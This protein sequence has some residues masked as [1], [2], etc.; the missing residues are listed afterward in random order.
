VEFAGRRDDQVKLRGFRVELGEV[1]AA[2]R[3]HPAVNAAAV[4]IRDTGFGDS[5][6]VGYVAVRDASEALTAELRTLLASRL[7]DYAVPAM[8]VALDHLPLTPNGKIDRKALPLPGS[9]EQTASARARRLLTPLE[10]QLLVIWEQV[11]GRDDLSVTDNFFDFGGNSLTAVRLFSQL[12]KVFGKDLPLATL[13]QAPTVERL[14][15]L[16]HSEG[17]STRWKTLVA[18]QPGGG[19]TPLF[20]VPGVGGNVLEFAR[21]A[22]LLGAEQPFYGAQSRGL[23]GKEPPLRVVQEMAREYLKEIRE[24]QPHGP[25]QLGG[26]CMG[27]IVAFEMAQQLEAAGERVALLALVDTPLT[28]SLNRK[29]YRLLSFLHPIFFVG[30]GISRHLSNLR[31]KSR[32]EWWAAVRVVLGI[33]GQMI[34]Q[35]DVYRGDR[36]VLY[37]DVVTAANY[38]AMANYVPREYRGRLHLFVASER[39]VNPAHYSRLDWAKFAAGGFSVF[40]INA[41][42]SGELLR[43]PY[44]SELAEQLRDA[45]SAGA[46]AGEIAGTVSDG[47][48]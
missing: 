5:Y 45:L 43:A 25:Y 12:R 39:P 47:D 26:A 31:G 37:Q 38:E 8:F 42:D 1:E 44:V 11:L 33:V 40:R 9:V 16:M 17:R 41:K 46:T 22:N 28:R 2:L 24:L 4:T 6:L 32:A 3:Q 19:S 48:S 23:D 7:P 21:L 35:R 29:R 15:A 36:N 27:G 10:N 20:M 30:Q 18:I 14:A 34:R 13:F